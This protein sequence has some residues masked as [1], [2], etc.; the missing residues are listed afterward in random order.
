MDPDLWLEDMIGRRRALPLSNRS[1]IDQV[2]GNPVVAIRLI[3][4]AHV[5]IDIRANVLP[6]QIRVS[7]NSGGGRKSNI[8]LTAPSPCCIWDIPRPG[9]AGFDTWLAIPGSHHKRNSNGSR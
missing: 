2:E 3:T 7:C 4:N 1:L 5:E 9:R 8:R 6:A